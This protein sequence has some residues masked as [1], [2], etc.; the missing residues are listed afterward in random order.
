MNKNL[1]W[2]IVLVLVVL[3]IDQILKIWIKTNMV[4]GENSYIDWGWKIK[5]AQILFVENR[6]MAFG[7]ELPF[8]SGK[9][10]LTSIRLI[11]ITFIGIY[12]Y[13]NTKKNLPIGFILT[14]SM[15]FAGALGNLIDS[16]FYGLIFEQ[17]SYGNV[18]PASFVPIG[19]GYAGF[20]HGKVVDMFYFP[21]FSLKFPP[22]FP[23]WGGKTFNFFEPVFNVADSMITVGVFI[24]LFFGNRW[25]KKVQEIELSSKQK[26]TKEQ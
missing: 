10:I 23:L 20:M 6:G 14:L 11:V 9:I 19:Q 13:K 12:I 15:I 26:K 21:L 3:I 4:I 1:K 18:A 7:M 2:A 5:W 16:M 17:S 25:F 22:N 8:D 24:L